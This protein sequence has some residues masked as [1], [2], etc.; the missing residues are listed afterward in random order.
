MGASSSV[1]SA[2]KSPSCHV[3]WRGGP[4][5]VQG[6]KIVDGRGKYLGMQCLA[7]HLGY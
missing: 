4:A 6:D 1:S 7:S 3:C 5:V 2:V